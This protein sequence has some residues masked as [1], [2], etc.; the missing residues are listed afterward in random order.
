M[1]HTFHSWLCGSSKLV[2]T[3]LLPAQSRFNTLFTQKSRSSVDLFSLR[4]SV[5]D[6]VTLRERAFSDEV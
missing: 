1:G 2:E 5:A 3:C 4:L 6:P